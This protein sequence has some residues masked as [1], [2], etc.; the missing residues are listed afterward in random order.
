MTDRRIYAV[1]VAVVAVLLAV[2]IVRWGD[3]SDTGTGVRG[4]GTPAAE[5]KAEQLLASYAEAGLAPRLDAEQL[6]DLLGE[7][8]GPV[9]RAAGDLRSGDVPRGA[10][11]VRLGVGGEFYVRPARVDREAMARA[12]LIVEAYCPEDL[13]AVRDLVDDLALND[14]ARR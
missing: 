9:C 5:A 4:A 11:L 10:L 8:G 1:V 6:A 12:L 3:R 14:V 13:P 7:N 2:M